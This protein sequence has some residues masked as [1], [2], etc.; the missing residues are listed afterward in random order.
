LA[1]EIITDGLA[2]GVTITGDTDV[3]GGIPIHELR[4]ASPAFEDEGTEVSVEEADGDADY[5]DDLLDAK[6]AVAANY[7]QQSDH[8]LS[9]SEREEGT[10]DAHSQGR[11]GTEG[12][13]A[14]ALQ[15]SVLFPPQECLRERDGCHSIVLCVKNLQRRMPA[16]RKDVADVQRAGMAR[17]GTQT[18]RG[19]SRTGRGGTA[20]KTKDKAEADTLGVKEAGR[21]EWFRG[22]GLGSDPLPEDKQFLTKQQKVRTCLWGTSLLLPE[23]LEK[24]DLARADQKVRI[25]GG[26]DPRAYWDLVY[27]ECRTIADLKNG[28]SQVLFADLDEND[29]TLAGFRQRVGKRLGELGISTSFDIENF[30]DQCHVVASLGEHIVVPAL[31][32]MQTAPFPGEA[33]VAVAQFRE[34]SARIF[35]WYETLPVRYRVL[36]PVSAVEAF[37]KTAL[38]WLAECGSLVTNADVATAFNPLLQS[39]YVPFARE[40]AAWPAYTLSWP[41]ADDY[42]LDV[43]KSFLVEGLDEV[44]RIQG[45]SDDPV[46]RRPWE[47][48]NVCET[49][50]IR[51]HAEDWLRL[52]LPTPSDRPV[53]AVPLHLHGVI[54]KLRQ[55]V[56]TLKS[57]PD[58]ALLAKSSQLFI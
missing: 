20:R 53:V 30:C 18:P 36:L 51:A 46:G 5:F 12:G 56:H 33:A 55:D 1:I 26:C 10:A 19:A 31:K 57:K 44:L 35:H 34:K 49:R 6:E 17:T 21:R 24:Y 39:Y 54:D 13:V 15:E 8:D 9:E 41:L 25:Q 28:L 27:T 45:C 37:S 43:G 40:P 16:D 14:E 23:L 4:R 32:A 2:T 50:V 58:T 22:K 29:Q 3:V 48:L 38:G 47:I 42:W 7:H 11:G 52:P